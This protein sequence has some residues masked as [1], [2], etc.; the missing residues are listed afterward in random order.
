MGG[1]GGGHWSAVIG[2]LCVAYVY[3]CDADKAAQIRNHVIL[4]APEVEMES[5]KWRAEKERERK[6]CV[7]L[8]ETRK[9]KKKISKYVARMFFL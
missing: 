3:G 6:V 7:V 9:E 2:E 5:R 1:G 8:D 4:M